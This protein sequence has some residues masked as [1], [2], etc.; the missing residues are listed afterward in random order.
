MFTSHKS[1]SVAAVNL[2]NEIANNNSEVKFVFFDQIHL[3]ESEVEQLAQALEK[4][5]HL[6][7]I[8]LLDCSLDEQ[9]IAKLIPAFEK[10]NNLIGVGIEKFKNDNTN[11]INMID[12]IESYIERNRTI[13]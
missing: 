6:S 3:T 12:K 5:T 13:I 11:T 4:N 7:Y 10:N 8:S 9:K 2:I 1:K